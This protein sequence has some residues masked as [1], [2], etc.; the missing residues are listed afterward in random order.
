MAVPKFFTTEAVI[1]MLKGR[2]GGLSD[3]AYA[4]TL[5]VSRQFMSDVLRGTR[6]PSKELLESIG[7]E[8][9]IVY[10]KKRRA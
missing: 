8:R 9:R 10:Q 1:A 5:G 4:K 7:L 3:C 2:Q 6:G